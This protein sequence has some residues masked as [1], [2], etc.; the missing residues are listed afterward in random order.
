[1]LQMWRMKSTQSRCDVAKANGIEISVDGFKVGVVE[2]FQPTDRRI[3]P[4]HEIGPFCAGKT[5][6]EPFLMKTSACAEKYERPSMSLHA[7]RRH[8]KTLAQSIEVQRLKSEAFR[9]L[10]GTGDEHVRGNR[11][12]GG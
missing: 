6:Y 7:G 12:I 2:S 3:E 11:T 1:M 4:V 10:G 9:E 8:G 5:S